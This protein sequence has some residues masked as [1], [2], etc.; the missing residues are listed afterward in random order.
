M[1]DQSANAGKTYTLNLASQQ[2]SMISAIEYVRN[3]GVN[4]TELG[5]F[6][7]QTFRSALSTALPDFVGVTNGFVEDAQG[8]RSLQMDIIL[9]DKLTA[10]PL[11]DSGDWMVLP[12]ECTYACCEV[13]TTVRVSQLKSD[14]TQKC[15]SYKALQRTAKL[16]RTPVPVHLYGKRQ[17]WQSLF[18][19]FAYRSDVSASPRV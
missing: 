7:E 11:L 15:R 6:V 16:G 5:S 2:E 4:A 13:K 10:S 3:S 18:F 8:R 1:S 9:Y 17:E 12:V 14:I 19:C